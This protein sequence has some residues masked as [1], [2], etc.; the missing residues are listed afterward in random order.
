MAQGSKGVSAIG[1]VEV[2]ASGY[3]VLSRVGRSTVAS[4]ERVVLEV[5]VPG[6]QTTMELS[7]RTLLIVKIYMYVH[8]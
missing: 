2:G 7:I 6:A 5:V 8:L 3:G 1:W 4:G